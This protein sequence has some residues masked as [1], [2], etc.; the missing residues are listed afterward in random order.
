M[1]SDYCKGAEPTPDTIELPILPEII[2]EPLPDEGCS[3]PG[4]VRN[5]KKQCVAPCPD[6]KTAPDAQGNCPCGTAKYNP[7]ESCCSTDG[8]LHKGQLPDGKGGCGC[9]PGQVSSG[10][11]IFK[12]C[13]QACGGNAYDTTKKC[14]ANETLVDKC[15][16]ACYDP[17]TTCCEDGNK[18]E[19][20]EKKC[21]RIDKRIKEMGEIIS[22]LNTDQKPEET[23]GPGTITPAKTYCLPGGIAWIR[24]YKPFDN[25]DPEIQN[26][27]RVHENIH[28]Q[29]CREY[30]AGEFG[31]R[32]H[33]DLKS[34]EVP[35]YTAGRDA[36]QST[37]DNRCKSK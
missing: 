5:E 19:K 2:P 25:L 8:K 6:G 27:I 23:L 17:G 18:D 16:G 14:C 9:P 26:A 30:G 13:V 36:L 3:V 35:A 31:R 1:C 15:G 34:I 12:K 20:C 33:E 22:G 24:F 7:K 32:T 11:W 29:Q 10:W 21:M 28:A 4:H 37:Y